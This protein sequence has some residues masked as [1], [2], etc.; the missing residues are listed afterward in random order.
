MTDV[1]ARWTTENVLALAPDVSS[2]RAA[3]GL[4]RPARW[5]GTGAAGE[6][7]WGLCAGSGQQPYQAIADLTGPAYKCSC[8]SRKFPC[9]HVLGLLLVWARGGVPEAGQPS[10]Y[11]RAWQQGRAAAAAGRG[12]AANRGGTADGG[13]E[14]GEGAPT[15]AKI[16]SEEKRAAAARRSQQRAGRVAAG[17]AELQV[18]LRDQVMAG[19]SGASASRYGHA[20][21]IAARMVDAQAGGLAGVL[22]RMS[23]I[24]ATGDGWPA[25]LLGEYAGL[26]L[27]TRAH[28]R[29]GELPPGLAAVVRSRIGYTTGR[30]E[31]LA[32]PPVTDRWQVLAVRDLP[33]APIP[34]RRT[35]LRGRVTRR[36]ALLLSFAPGGYFGTNPDA[37]LAVGTELHAD[38]HYYPA[39]PPVRAVIG[40]RRGSPA[41]GSRPGQPGD[42]AALLGGWAAALEQDPWLT[43]WPALLAGTPAKDS[44]RWY[45]A[46][47]SGAAVP[48]LGQDSLWPLLAVSGGHPVTV[49]GEWSPAGLIPLTV[50]HGDQAV[51]L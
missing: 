39:P 48:L 5:S 28:D 34:A 18:W 37:G 45:L 38:L 3:A 15:V 7:V 12:A 44:G 19:L 36:F 17:A 8:P 32:T 29:L 50:W 49:A 40:T 41:R 14:A 31:V 11:A 16:T 33:D 23:V 47:L 2:Q 35:W 27:L 51:P 42:L 26:H 46:D 10:D 13:T 4:A 24:P 20:E 9:K 30:D 22:R 25:R 6:L 1:V 43:E 21:A